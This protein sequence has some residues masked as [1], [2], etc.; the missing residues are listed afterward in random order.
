MTIGTGEIAQTLMNNNF[1]HKAL[2]NNNTLRKDEWIRLDTTVIE[3]ARV[4]LNAVTDLTNLGFV[5]RINGLRVSIL[6]YQR[7]TRTEE[8]NVSM[9]PQIMGRVERQEFDLV[10][11]PLPI[12]HA[13]Y[14]IGIRMLETSRNGGQPLDTSWARNKTQD[15][16][17]KVEKTLINGLGGYKYGSGTDQGTLYGYLDFPDRATF[18]IPVAWDLVGA[19]GEDIVNDVLAMRQL[20]IAAKHY[21]PYILYVP[22]NYEG[23]MDADY[24]AAK[25]DNTIRDRIEAI[26]SIE[27]VKV[28]DLLPDDNVVLVQM[29]R[30]SVE[31]IEGLPLSNTQWDSRGG[32][33]FNFLIWTIMVPRQFSDIDGNSGIVHGSV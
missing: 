9:D 17:E 25:G 8:V 26:K 30:D 5:E 2:R 10:S 1:D 28:L 32:M 4:R 19:T 7:E 33:T 11:T 15:V 31:M 13:D 3:T 12:Y 29:T 22:P 18:T 23:K 16:A 20:A 27:E 6:Q 14:N 21:G 24:S